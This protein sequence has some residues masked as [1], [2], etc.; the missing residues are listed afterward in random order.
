MINMIKT[1]LEEAQRVQSKTD[2]AR[3]DAMTDEDIRKAIEGDPDSVPALTEDWF[4]KAHW[5]E[6]GKNALHLVQEDALVLA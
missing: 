2:W 6:Q 5:V 1:T 3:V 4:A